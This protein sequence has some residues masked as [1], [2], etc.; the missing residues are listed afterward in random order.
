MLSF[1]ED[2]E[3]RSAVKKLSN[4]PEP[5]PKRYASQ[6]VPFYYYDKQTHSNCIFIVEETAII[7]YNLDTQ[8]I[9][10]KYPL[11][12]WLLN[13]GD[14]YG[15]LNA[16]NNTMYLIFGY[17]HWMKFDFNAEKWELLNHNANCPIVHFAFFPSPINQLHPSLLNDYRYCY[18][19]L[20]K[21]SIVLSFYLK[22]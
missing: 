3:S 14:P 11:P 12:Q 15:A 6:C 2:Q 17:S 20:C 21:P 8:R 1:F 5:F 16:I 7:K 13:V 18:V 22:R 10:A 19:C 4:P 9:M